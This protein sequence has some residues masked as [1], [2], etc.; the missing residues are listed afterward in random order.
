MTVFGKSRLAESGIVTYLL[1]PLKLRTPPTFP[2]VCVAALMMVPLFPCPERSKA[3]VPEM[4]FVS[5][6]QCPTRL[7]SRTALGTM[8]VAAMPTPP[9]ESVI[10]TDKVSF[11][12]GKDVTL[13]PLTVCAA[14]VVVPLPVNGVPPPELEIV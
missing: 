12:S 2:V 6:V 4:S 8:S 11:P 9:R 1:P 7:V 5:N 13:M 3:V 10:V 14:P